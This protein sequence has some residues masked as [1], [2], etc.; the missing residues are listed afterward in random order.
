[1]LHAMVRIQFVW[2]SKLCAF[3]S[4]AFAR[5]LCRGIWRKAVEAQIMKTRM[6]P[7][8]G[9]VNETFLGGKTTSNILL[10]NSMIITVPTR[11]VINAL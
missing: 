7:M 11:G 4:Y 5:A 6:T 8:I 9:I 1:M 10:I 3:N 2:T